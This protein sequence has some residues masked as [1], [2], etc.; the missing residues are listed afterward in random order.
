MPCLLYREPGGARLS[1]ST[2]E[3]LGKT[4]SRPDT[5]PNRASVRRE[6][7][8]SMNPRAA[9]SPPFHLGVS[10][11]SGAA[12]TMLFTAR[13]RRVRSRRGARSRPHLRVRT[14]LAAC[15]LEPS[16]RE[17]PI[18]IAVECDETSRHRVSRIR[19]RRDTLCDVVCGERDFAFHRNAV[20]PL[21]VALAQ[22][23]HV[24]PQTTA[25]FARRQTTRGAP[26]TQHDCI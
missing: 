13:R 9:R 2:V 3:T 6:R 8:T 22:S 26:Q 12:L 1:T 19:E 4:K 24:A 23:F 10:L 20:L 11:R 17:Q 18:R 7:I 21:V 25:A 15:L 16:N 5:S 14:K